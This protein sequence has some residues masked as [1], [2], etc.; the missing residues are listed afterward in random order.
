M[1]YPIATLIVLIAVVSIVVIHK[2]LARPRHGEILPAG[3]MQKKYNLYAENRP[4]IQIDPANVP[5][6]LRDL[7]PM[8]EMWGIGD[9]II[10]G[11]FCKKASVE[12]KQ[13]LFQ[14][15]RGRTDQINKWLDSF[16][17][18]M[19]SD[20]AAFM[21]MLLALDEMGLYPS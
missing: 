19:T 16:Q 9:D 4:D 7:I 8:A 2:R 18:S 21:Y 6:K 3:V 11:D 12:E 14:A 20:A 17:S 10:R 5:T 1:A 13:S 15:V